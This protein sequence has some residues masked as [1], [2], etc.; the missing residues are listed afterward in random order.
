MNP[1]GYDLRCSLCGFGFAD[2]NREEVFHCPS[3]HASISNVS[4]TWYSR[5][6]NRAEA[7][8]AWRSDGI[9]LRATRRFLS[10]P[11]AVACC[12]GTIVLCAWLARLIFGGA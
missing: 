2:F 3:C 9:S 12:V 1:S 5:D 6:K 7:E 4:L 10:V 11:V 8:L